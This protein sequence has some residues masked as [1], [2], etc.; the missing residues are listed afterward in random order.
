MTSLP[1]WMGVGK[2]KKQLEKEKLKKEAELVETMKQ[3][4][5]SLRYHIFRETL[6]TSLILF[7][8]HCFLTPIIRPH[9]LLTQILY[10][11]IAF[12]IIFRSTGSVVRM[13]LEYKR[14]KKTIMTNEKRSKR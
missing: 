1:S 2:L 4:E 3:R 13:F 9:S 6:I 11:A 8:E 12:A 5:L 14:F 10:F 7:L